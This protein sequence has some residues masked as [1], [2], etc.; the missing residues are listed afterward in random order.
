ME[1][2]R[3]IWLRFVLFLITNN[4]QFVIDAQ[5]TRSNELTSDEPKLL[6]ESYVSKS[7][8]SELD[9][10][11]HLKSESTQPELPKLEPQVSKD[12]ELQS[13]ESKL[14]ESESKESRD[15]KLES[16]A[17]K[18]P[19]SIHDV[20]NPSTSETH[21]VKS[22]ESISN[23]LELPKSES[24]KL[25]L[26]EFESLKLEFTTKMVMFCK[27]Y[28][29]EQVCIADFGEV[30][31]L[32]ET[33]GLEKKYY[34]KIFK[35]FEKCISVC[36]YSDAV[37]VS[38]LIIET[39]EES[40][41]L[42][43]QNYYEKI[44]CTTSF[45]KK[46][47]A[48]YYFLID[49]FISIVQEAK[50]SATGNTE[51]PTIEITKF[52]GKLLS[53]AWS[54]MEIG[55][56]FKYGYDIACLMKT[57]R[58]NIINHISAIGKRF[59]IKDTDELG[60]KTYYSIYKTELK[61]FKLEH[62]KKFIFDAILTKDI[63]NVHYSLFAVCTTF[64]YGR[65]WKGSNL[66]ATEFKYIYNGIL[67]LYFHCNVNTRADTDN[68]IHNLT[69]RLIQIN[70][71]M[72]NLKTFVDK[73]IE[74]KLNTNDISNFIYI[75][76]SGDRLEIEK[77]IAILEW[78]SEM[79]PM[80]K[81]FGKDV[82]ETLRDC[83]NLDLKCY[84]FIDNFNPNNN[85][86]IYYGF[87]YC[88]K[89]E[90]TNYLKCAVDAGTKFVEKVGDEISVN[91]GKVI[92]MI[93]DKNIYSNKWSNEVL[94][95]I[96]QKGLTGHSKEVLMVASILEHLTIE[97]F[98][99]KFTGTQPK[100]LSIDVLFSY[101]D[102]MK[103]NFNNDYEYLFKF[104]NIFNSYENFFVENNYLDI[105]VIKKIPL[106]IL[107]KIFSSENSGMLWKN[108][109]D[110]IKDNCSFSESFHLYQEY[111]KN[112]NINCL[113]NQF[114]FYSEGTSWSC[115]EFNN[116]LQLTIPLKFT[117]KCDILLKTLKKIDFKAGGLIKAI[118]K[119]NSQCI[120][121]ENGCESI[122]IS[123]DVQ[124]NIQSNESKWTFLQNNLSRVATAL[125]LTSKKN[126]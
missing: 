116:W 39:N 28:Y 6:K 21:E 9:K 62:I 76:P 38:H 5:E 14:H 17:L 13:N 30:F 15:L 7:P 95:N 52:I 87:I 89:V 100:N 56:L 26:T 57:G 103:N 45:I 91:F 124:L 118:Q 4:G 67:P 119:I 105:A 113:I 22:S 49:V 94:V 59:N 77:V 24:H 93:K 64:F 111:E 1:M 41:D 31:K 53:N 35:V 44:N 51:W 18:L 20:S 88:S 27:H 46:S 115:L 114:V 55:L 71:E 99:E 75:I 102:K 54:N 32:A 23:E 40:V 73:A 122:M 125:K 65:L 92:Q 112:N 85:F 80:F 10:S 63:K 3:I 68:L 84:N 33:K 74:L 47:R 78:Y 104:I 43:W 60:F 8:E 96:L 25:N 19:K 70:I 12:T 101:V 97:K 108:I 117:N 72:K 11:K 90:H 110:A 48:T 98:E 42:L 58:Y 121:K 37:I 81:I 66:S 86:L 69:G 107:N 29:D 106:F 79:Q 109:V 50:N 34:D 83:H 36:Q 2:K 82:W 16:K 123:N 126:E 120:Y 61:K